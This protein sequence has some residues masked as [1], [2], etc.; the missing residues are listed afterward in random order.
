MVEGIYSTRVEL[1]EF[2]DFTVWVECPRAI[3]LARGLERDGESAPNCWLTKWMPEEDRY[4][5]EQLPQTR[6]DLVYDGSGEVK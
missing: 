4:V 1:K 2:Y 5:S 6:A 3:R